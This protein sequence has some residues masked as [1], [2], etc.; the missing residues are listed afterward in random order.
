L[1]VSTKKGTSVCSEY[2]PPSTTPKGV[3]LWRL[4]MFLVNNDNI[5]SGVSVRMM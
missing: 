3:I 1:S 5:I 4:T 2:L